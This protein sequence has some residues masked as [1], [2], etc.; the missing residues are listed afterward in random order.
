[1]QTLF[2]TLDEAI[3]GA[4]A[5]SILACFAWGLL[6]LLLS[7]CHLA[8]I[9]L[10][11]GFVGSQG[12]ISIRRAFMLSCAYSLGI[13]ATIAAAGVLT[14]G[15][16]RAVGDIGPCGNYIVAA[17]FFVIGLHLLEILPLPLPGGRQFRTSHRGAIAAFVLGLLFGLALGPCTFAFMAP[18]LGVVFRTSACSA[19]QGMVLIGAYATGHCSVIVFAGTFTN[20]VQR[21][22]D[23]NEKSKAS[24]ILRR[25]CGAAM[26]AGGVYMVYS[27]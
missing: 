7:P 20:L 23:W 12:R 3:R 11:V 19:W 14:A 1:M 15:V 21:Y 6:S 2:S 17:V 24:I 18:V 9:P 5:V 13:I 10:V 16:G 4:G 8:S 22:L 26:L 27:A 25:A